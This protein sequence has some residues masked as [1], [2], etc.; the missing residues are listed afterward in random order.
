MDTITAPIPGVTATRDGRTI[1]LSGATYPVRDRI[2]AAG[3]RWHPATKTW[4]GGQVSLERLAGQIT[5]TTAAPVP[6]GQFPPTPEQTAILAAV[7]TGRAV[8]VE[9]LAGTG[10]TST[11]ELIARA[12]PAKRILLVVFNKSMQ[13]EAQARMPRNVEARTFDSLGFAGA[14]AEAVV[15]FRAQRDAKGAGGP[16]RKLTDVV[17]H[18]GLDKAPT[19]YVAT[20]TS[21]TGGVVVTRR[22]TQVI[23]PVRAA[24]AALRTVEAWCTSAD[25][26]ITAAH[27]P[28]EVADEDDDHAA[29]AAAIVPIAVRAWADLTSAQGQLRITNGHLTKMWAMTRPDLTQPGSGARMAPDMILVDEAQDTAPV[30]EAVM[31]AQTVQT[32]WVGDTWQSIYAWRGAVNALTNVEPDD[33]KRLPL[34][35]SWRFGPEVAGAGNAFLGRLGSR[36]TVDGGGKPGT[37]LGAGS[38]TDPDAVLCRTNAGMIGEVL[39]LLEGGRKAAVTPGTRQDLALLA[40]TVRW[41]MGGLPPA[42]LH[43][44]LAAFGSWREVEVAVESGVADQKVEMLHKLVTEQTIDVIERVVGEMLEI[45]Q[46]GA[47]DAVVVITAHK[48]KGLQWPRVKIG[49]DFPQPR[50]RGESV[51]EPGREEQKLGYVAVTRAQLALDP[52]S[53]SWAL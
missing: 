12:H 32:V 25:A 11:L 2:K 31:R 42:R 10:K 35:K 3:F 46:A 36:W 45:G 51:V 8:V 29:A 20:V 33:A 41:L 39:A 50:R 15:K 52:G 18:L 40:G 27:V 6:A 21:E 34:T 49:G 9:A 24:S 48:S 30:C 53:L 28:A 19:R 17:R 22:E 38:M 23:Q 1:A 13:T 16:I 43:D 47:R 7:S 14:P 44:D 26:Q 5:P 4:R 37:V